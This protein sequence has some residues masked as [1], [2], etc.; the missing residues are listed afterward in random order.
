MATA[1]PKIKVMELIF[2]VPRAV[3]DVSGKYPPKAI[4]RPHKIPPT[5]TAPR[6]N[7][8]ILIEDGKQSK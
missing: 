5:R 7:L 8:L 6:V 4:P 3:K 1:I 2:P